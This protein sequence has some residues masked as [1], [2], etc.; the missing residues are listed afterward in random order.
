MDLDLDVSDSHLSIAET[1]L[2]QKNLVIAE[3]NLNL[4]LQIC[5]RIGYVQGKINYYKLFSELQEQKNNYQSAFENY[6]LYKQLND[7]IRLTEGSELKF[8]FRETEGPAYSNN[9]RNIKN[10][11]LLSLLSLILII[12]P[13]VLIRYKR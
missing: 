8:D 11:W 5:N 9:E 2:K 10:L 7:S 4:A 13:F 1:A 6:K 12:V 3:E